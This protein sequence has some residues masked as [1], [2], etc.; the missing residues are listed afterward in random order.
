MKKLILTLIAAGSVALPVFAL[1]LTAT[2]FQES[3][4]LA[5]KV[6][7]WNKQCGD[8]PDYDEV[9]SKKRHALSRELGEFVAL[10]NDEL[11]FL[12]GPVSPDAP[13]RLIEECKDR[14]KLMELEARIAL[15]NIKCLGVTG[16]DSECTA[17][18]A[19]IEADKA[20]LQ[21]ESEEAHEYFDPK[22][23]VS[24]RVTRVIKKP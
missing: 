23:W 1:P 15:N 18:A 20:D 2:I 24:L 7:A 5:K 22:H 21:R 13:A 14:R 10:V 9:C 4:R 16:A 17:E 6:A 3:A 19:A 12:N 8:K 11:S